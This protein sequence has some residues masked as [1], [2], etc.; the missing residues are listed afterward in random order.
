MA[1]F[2]TIYASTVCGA[3][4]DF[5][6]IFK[7]LCIVFEQRIE[8]EISFSSQS[9][10]INSPSTSESSVMQ[11]G[12]K[13]FRST[14]PNSNPIHSS[15][16]TKLLF[17]SGR[18]YGYGWLKRMANPL[19]KSNWKAKQIDQKHNKTKPKKTISLLKNH[20][21]AESIWKVFMVSKLL[22]VE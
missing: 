10:L 17:K 15:V 19:L 12:G 21:K 4:F 7:K 13:L 8:G 16:K 3:S 20:P 6:D 2:L 14:G 5:F 11:F 18:N 9:I 1:N 22:D